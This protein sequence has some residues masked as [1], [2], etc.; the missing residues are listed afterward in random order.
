MFSQASPEVWQEEISVAFSYFLNMH[1]TF[2]CQYFL[3]N[4]ST[5]GIK[6]LVFKLL[7]QALSHLTLV[8]KRRI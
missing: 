1:Y 8:K 7:S 6:E 5:G 3:L 2:D 4:V